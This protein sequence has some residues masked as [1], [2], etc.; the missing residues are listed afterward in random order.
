MNSE[1]T[2]IVPLIFAGEGCTGKTALLTRLRNPDEP[3]PAHCLGTYQ[4]T[5]T[6]W[7]QPGI[8]FNCMDTVTQGR[9][10]VSRAMMA[11]G[12]C[13]VVYVHTGYGSDDRN[14]IRK[15]AQLIRTVNANAT[16]VAVRS[17]CDSARSPYWVRQY[18]EMCAAAKLQ[19]FAVDSYTGA[20]IDELRAHLCELARTNFQPET[21]ELL[22]AVARLSRMKSQKAVAS[23][24]ELGF[25]EKT[26][27]QLQRLG[28]LWRARATP[29]TCII[30]PTA[31]S[32][33]ASIGLRH[34]DGIAASQAEVLTSFKR[35]LG[36]ASTAQAVYDVLEG[37]LLV[38]RY[39]CVIVPHERD[40]RPESPLDVKWVKCCDMDGG[41]TCGLARQLQSDG[42]QR[43]LGT[44]MLN[45]VCNLLDGRP[46][47]IGNVG[48]RG[49]LP[50]GTEIGFHIDCDSYIYI[51]AVNFQRDMNAVYRAITQLR[52]L[53]H[54]YVQIDNEYAFAGVQ[55]GSWLPIKNLRT[56]AKKNVVKQTGL[57]WAAEARRQL[58]PEELPATAADA[59]EAT[60]TDDDTDMLMGM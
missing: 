39:D 11:P 60:Q 15:W 8:V 32:Q 56:W 34:F 6:T 50:D 45:D 12:P 5:F 41:I 53:A 40:C 23:L 26:V 59:S 10:A 54:T 43:E 57:N 17:S 37:V 58:L 2:R 48:V 24:S 47:W 44:I 33:C 19:P 35:L 18:E 30:D 46:L 25:D 4:C 49:T 28:V 16:I 13:I 27:C 20:G 52:R 51:K 42:F 38:T 36:N 55:S 31:L 14:P 9:F 21:A 1:Q 3:P 7:T 29:S 22:E